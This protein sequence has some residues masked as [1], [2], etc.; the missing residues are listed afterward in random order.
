MTVGG[1]FLFGFLALGVVAAG[2]FICV[3]LETKAMGTFLTTL[4]CGIIVVAMLMGF[5]WY[6]SNTESGKRAVKSQEA[7]FN[8]GIERRVEVYDVEGE[9][10]KEYEGRFDVTYDDD[11][12]LFDDENGH[13]HIIYYST[14]NV[15]IDELGEENESN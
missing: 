3:S 7:N 15:I 12:I 5:R 2:V 6:Y 13:R 1:W 14:G 4:I 10:I 8:A 11:R 9:L